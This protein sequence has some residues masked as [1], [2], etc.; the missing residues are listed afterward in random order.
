MFTLDTT[1]IPQLLKF[2]AN[3][4]IGTHLNVGENRIRIV[5]RYQESGSTRE[6]SKEIKIV[7][8]FDTNIPTILKLQPSYI[9]RKAD[10]TLDRVALTDPA[11]FFT[12]LP[13]QLQNKSGKYVTSLKEYDLVFQ[14]SGVDRVR[15]TQAAARFLRTSL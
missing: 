7:I 14:L 8:F 4:V 5:G 10:N 13:E 12:I 11:L 3:A 15:L 6:V 9:N 1:G 2:T